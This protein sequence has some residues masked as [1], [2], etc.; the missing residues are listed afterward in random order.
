MKRCENTVEFEDPKKSVTNILKNL[1]ATNIEIRED[2]RGL[3]VKYEI[4]DLVNEWD[5]KN[6]LENELRRLRLNFQVR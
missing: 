4:G 2:Y 1:G 5:V 3:K 6:K